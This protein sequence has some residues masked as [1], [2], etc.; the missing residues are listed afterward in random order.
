MKLHYLKYL[1]KKVFFPVFP[2]LLVIILTLLSSTSLAGD[3]FAPPVLYNLDDYSRDVE[4]GDFN[5]DG[6]NDLALLKRSGIVSVR[7]GKGDGT[8]GGTTDFTVPYGPWHMVVKDFSNDGV[9][10]IAVISYIY[11]DALTILL[12]NGDGTFITHQE[13]NSGDHMQHSIISEDFNNDGETDL[14][15]GNGSGVRLLS[16]NG[17]GTFT[18]NSQIDITPRRLNNLA[19]GDFN[20][21]GNFDIFVAN[22]NDFGHG[23]YILLGKGDYSFQVLD[24]YDRFPS[25]GSAVSVAA[26]GD[27]FNGDGKI[28]IAVAS[29]SY[30]NALSLLPG[31]GDG[32][33]QPSRKVIS[34]YG[35]H[36]EVTTADM[37]CDGNRDIIV[38]SSFPA[39][40]I[41]V[42]F[43]N[44]DGTFLSAD[45]YYTGGI[46]IH[47]MSVGDLN[48]DG[49]VDI[50]VINLLSQTLSILMNTGIAC[51]PQ[52][53]ADAG[54]VQI[55]EQT[56]PAGADVLL[57]GS[58]SW[59]DNLTYEW[60]WP[61]GSATGISP[62]VTLPAGVTEVTLTVSDGNS[63][64]RDTVLI[65]VED[66]IAPS[67][68][69][70]ING[71]PGNA[72]WY[73]S[74]V[75]VSIFAADSGSGVKEIRYRVNSGVE[76]VVSGT[77]AALTL[78]SEGAFT[79]SYRAVDNA[80][81]V[82]TINTVSGNIDKIPPA[83]TIISPTA[84]DYPISQTIIIDYMVSDTGSGLLSSSASLDGVALNQG[85]AVTLYSLAPGSHTFSLTAND[86]AGNSITQNI[87]FSITVTSDSLSELID[88]LYAIGEIDNKG[89]ATSLKQQAQKGRTNALLNHIDAQADKHISTDGADILRRAVSALQ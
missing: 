44:G 64:D 17:D 59:G 39:T 70:L 36:H 9:L 1:K 65:T 46:Y 80:G 25:I 15:I 72:G 32:T 85:Q 40:K 87:T 16:G 4:M 45:R 55:V 79:V 22:H 28:D 29:N 75:N 74:D 5:G 69:A 3:I 33:F 31:N 14:A 82:G 24:L 71:V 7:L 88:I 83:L 84:S 12:G 8:F 48:N 11:S 50:A 58:A 86:V 81:N 43:G 30:G 41:D 42:L 54:S 63:L 51:I 78:S 60:T 10:D 62:T 89:M 66:T 27:D 6:N 2:F 52:I 26:A 76:Q 47:G 34:I 57:D 19:A 67:S 20:G 73:L 53:T 37:N 77:R 13:M 38:T 23:P 61:G 68:S 49:N 56:S 18:V 21:D 35:G